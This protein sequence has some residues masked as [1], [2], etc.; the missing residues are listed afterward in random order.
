M[1]T[2][3]MFLVVSE[4]SSVFVILQ[5]I[6]NTLAIL[7]G[8]FE[9]T[10]I[11]IK[12]GVKIFTESFYFIKFPFSDIKFAISEKHPPFPMTHPIL[13]F[14]LIAPLV[15]KNFYPITRGSVPFC[16]SFISISVFESDLRRLFSRRK[17]ISHKLWL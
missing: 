4:I 6:K 7:L 11:A 3:S 17:A 14:S 12:V 8:V 5:H 1:K 13:E 10:L 16:F 9:L 15:L 2:L